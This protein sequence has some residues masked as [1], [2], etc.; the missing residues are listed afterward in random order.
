M[1]AILQEAFERERPR[2]CRDC[3]MPLPFRVE[4][5]EAAAANWEVGSARQRCGH[6]RARIAAIVARLWAQ[7]D[8]EE[9]LVAHGDDEGRR[10]H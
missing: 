1:L 4:R 2:D 8:L 7:Y 9:P 6:S 10:L 5:P 3:R